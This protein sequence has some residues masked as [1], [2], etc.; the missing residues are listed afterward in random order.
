[1]RY[2]LSIILANALVVLAS[3]VS[4][5][6]ARASATFT[7]V[8]LDGV[9]EGFNDPTSVAPVGGN[10]GTTVGEQRLN[11]FQYAA[12]IWGNLLNS[13]VVIRVDAKFDP[14][15]CTTNSAV[16]GS[17]GPKTV[18]RDFAGAPVSNTW[19]AQAQANSLF[20]G[21]LSAGQDDINATFSSTIGTPGCL[22]SS[23]WYYGLDGNPPSGKIDFVAVLLHE[24]GH[25]L[26]FLS[27]V[28]LSTGAKLSGLDDAYMRHLEDHTTGKAYPQ[29]TD[30]ERV[31]ASINTGNLHWTGANVEA[32]SGVLSAG[33]V[34]T[35]VRMFAPNPAQSGSSVSHWDT[36]L[37]PNESMEPIYTGPLHDVGLGLELFA[38][39]GW[40]IGSTLPEVTIAATD[41]T[42]A[43][44]GTTTGMFTVSR[45][46]SMAADLTVFYSVGGTATAGSDYTTLSGS[47]LILSGQSSATITVTP[48]DDSV[49]GEGDETVVATLTANAAYTVG[50][51]SS[52]TVTITDND[53]ATVTIDATDPNASEIGPDSGT[54]TV[55]R[56]G[57][58]TNS[59][60]VFYSVSGTAT[61]GSDYVA[62]PG[63]VVI[64]VGQSS[65]AITVTPI[66]DVL[67]ETDETVI[68]TLTL[69]AFYNVG[70][71]S[72]ATVTITDN[73][74]APD[75]LFTAP[76]PGNSTNLTTATFNFLST[77]AGS[78]FGCSLDGAAFTACTSPKTYT[79]LKSGN[80]HFEVRATAG[81]VTDPTPASFDWTIDRFAPNTM[82]TSAPP[83]LTNNPVA[84]F[85]FS[86]TE[87]EG[88]F[89]CSLDGGPF[90]DCTSPSTTAPL[91]DGKHSFKVKAVDAAGNADRTPAKASWTLDTQAPQ[92]SIITAPTNPT[93]TTSAAFKFSSTEK[94]ST[95]ECNLDGA[96]F[97]P[98]TSAPI[99]TGLSITPHHIDVR[100]IDAAGNITSTPAPWDWTITP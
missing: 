79:R 14:L 92:T 48:I 50:S 36:A 21:D 69:N 57:T 51:P 77:V 1:M 41:G 3:L 80:H 19:Y 88:G 29:M 96:G 99:F 46:G 68:A 39:L 18:H 73:D 93:S 10:S 23:G 90:T 72:S 8:N 28:N 67:V 33:R 34:G 59:L 91:I 20:G 61:A 81:G 40:T 100:A 65:A 70:T 64:P 82:I 86:S 52:A 83:A 32:A 42:A 37:S 31:A 87:A 95:F 44:Q 30:A 60:T 66:N 6:P 4:A 11:A 85:E 78:T 13:P 98:C 12:D 5:Q 75:T 71:P 53:L 84:T 26:G 7:I 22:Q 54:F 63:S 25:G 74:V 24:L 15:S 58:T 16:L 47:V 62:L 55:S 89:L 94:K 2:S 49:I 43:E 97:L 56:T 27:L 35:H 9:G 76:T 38:D 45:T 17:A